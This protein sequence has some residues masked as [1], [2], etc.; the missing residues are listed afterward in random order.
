MG[1]EINAIWGAQTILIW[2]YDNGATL[3]NSLILCLMFNLE[4]KVSFKKSVV[5]VYKV[6]VYVNNLLYY[7]P[8]INFLLFCNEII[9]VS[10]RSEIFH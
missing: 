1:K 6:T 8:S 2:I 9:L 3:G 10:L 7:K 4:Q 5:Q